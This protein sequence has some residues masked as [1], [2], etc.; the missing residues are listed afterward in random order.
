MLKSLIFEN[1]I[2][3]YW[4]YSEKFAQGYTY[5][6][7]LNEKTAT[8]V[9][10][11]CQ[12]SD[13]QADSEYSI[14]AWLLDENGKA[15]QEI[16][17]VQVKT[18]KKRKRI[19]V[20]KAPYYAVGDGK[21]LNTKALQ[22][23]IDDCGKGE[24]V[25]F[26]AGVFLSGALNLHDDME[27]YLEKGAVLQGSTSAADYL[28]KRP[29]RFEG[30]DLLC[31]GSLMNIGQAEPF[32]GYNCKNVIIRGGG[33][34]RGGGN[35]LGQDVINIEHARLLVEDKE[36]LKK[37]KEC[38]TMKTMAGR[39]R[40]RLINVSNSQGVI[41]EGISIENG[42]AW[43]LHVL[44]SDDVVTA[45]CTFHSVHINNGDGFDPDSS[46]NCTIFNCNFYNSD[47]SIAIKSGRNPDGNFVNRCCKNIKIFDCRSEM[48]HGCSIGSEMSGGVEDVY[49][50]DCDFEKSIFG[51]TVK[52]TKKRGGFVRNFVVKNCIAPRIMVRTVPY[53][54]DGVAAATVP[55][56]ENF[57]F[58]N[59]K[60]S[61]CYWENEVKFYDCPAIS[62]TGFDVKENYLKNV[63]FRNVKIIGRKDGTEHLFELNYLQS[64]TFENISII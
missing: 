64:V 13:L 37:A 38:Q 42:P 49:I 40:P 15:V 25:Y 28:P 56:F 43:N 54:D 22:K 62:L 6:V 58:E 21:T 29:S 9:K 45:N 26:P 14:V 53:N 60:L 51:I 47:D 1:E 12:F 16:G 8:T 27:V 2:I 24:T 39:Y 36:Y 4:D 48:G 63:T 44:Y 41:I 33:T 30:L 18:P 59:V 50:W 57:L 52:A 3:V 7:E 32:G 61:G 20:T 55:V 5:R 19:D 23:A 34:V 31:Y 46:T 17:R 10:T 11:H 35:E